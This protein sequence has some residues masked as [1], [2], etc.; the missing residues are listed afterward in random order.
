VRSLVKISHIQQVEITRNSYLQHQ[1]I[2]DL[3]ET[4]FCTIIKHPKDHAKLLKHR[5]TDLIISK[6]TFSTSKVF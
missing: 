6:D 2:N 3:M 4:K 5:P 1:I